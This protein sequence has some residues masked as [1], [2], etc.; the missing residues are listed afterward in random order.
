MSLLLRVT[1]PLKQLRPNA[2]VPEDHTTGRPNPALGYLF[3][4]H[5]NPS[6]IWRRR[7]NVHAHTSDVNT[8]TSPGDVRQTGSCAL[9]DLEQRRHED[10]RDRHSSQASS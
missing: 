1:L 8:H 4:V 5:E 2:E 6:P 10:A 9:R 3:E 7:N